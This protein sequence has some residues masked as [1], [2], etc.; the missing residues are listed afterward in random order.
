MA[1]LIGG[2]NSE[3]DTGYNVANSC[4]FNDDDSPYLNKTITHGSSTSGRKFTFSAWVKKS[5]IGGDMALFS[6]GTNGSNESAIRFDEDYI[7]F[8]QVYGGAVEIDITTSSL[9]RDPSAWMHVVVAVDTEQG[10]NT[11]RVKVY[12][13]GTQVTDLSGTTY[14]DE[15]DDLIIGMGLDTGNGD[16]E[17]GREQANTRNYWD[18]YMAEVC[19][20]D[21]LQLAASSFGEFDEDSP[22]IW[23]PKDVSG[24]TFGNNGAYLDFEDSANLGNDKNGG[25]DFT[26][27]N[28]AAVDQAVDTPTNNF[29]TMNPLS[30]NE[31]T[32]TEGNCVATSNSNPRTDDN[33]RGTMGVQSGKWYWEVKST[34]DS[35]IC[36]AGICKDDLKMGDDL[37]GLNGVYAIQNAGGT[38]AYRRENG[39]TAETTGFPN[40]TNG[41]IFNMAFDAD[42]A[43][44]YVGINGSYYSQDGSDGDPAGG[45]NET[46]ASIDTSR[47][48]LPFFEAR[49]TAQNAQGNF[50]GCPGFAISSG[51]ADANGYGNFEYAVPSGYYA[52]CTKNLAEYG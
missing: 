20:I 2:A 3:A 10:T 45:S 6:T 22:T 50:G 44:L 16:H 9:Y 37:S 34:G 15:D 38:Y 19:W 36:V 35:N 26:E 5:K 40:P 25:T 46:Y 29:C 4:R 23:K 32:F 14:P 48:W 7:Q 12:V 8:Y 42:N 43:K 21:G 30:V 33:C 11:N 47:H 51:N 27:N 49:G 39:T 13:N 52:L 24:L 41:Q 1:F 31:M 17:I 28:I 18:G